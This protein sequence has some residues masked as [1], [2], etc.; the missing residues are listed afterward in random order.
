MSSQFTSNTSQRELPILY[1]FRRCPYAMRARLAIAE[2]N[3]IVELREVLLRN[4]PDHMLSLS[5][6]GTVPILWLPD[7]SVID[8]SY[9]IMIWALSKNNSSIF[10]NKT[11]YTE[12]ISLVDNKF[13]YHLDR[14]KYSSRFSNSNAA[15]HRDLALEILHQIENIL[16]EP[17]LNGANPGFPDFA[18]LPFVRQYRIADIDWFDDFNEIPK[19]KAWLNNFLESNGFKNIM[20][21][22]PPWKEGLPGVHFNC[23]NEL[24]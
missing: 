14:Y 16:N 6:K 3:I 23:K 4:K 13:K 15:D 2:T 22:Y 1:S 21:K 24:L 18:I 9:D 8:E 17:W 20:Q 11:E 19:I 12:L 5:S 10:S 7:G